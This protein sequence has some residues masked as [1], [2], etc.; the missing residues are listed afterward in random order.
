MN[1]AT[2]NIS[3]EY[4]ITEI[5]NHFDSDYVI[6]AIKDKLDNLDFSSSLIQPNA[7][8][9]FEENFK[10]MKENFPGD[11]SNINIVRIRI[12]REIIDI[13]CSKFNL[14]FNEYDDTIDLYTA[15]FYLYEFLICN[16]NKIMISFFSSFII[17]NKDM[18]YEYINND[19]KKRDM[20]TAYNKKIFTDPKYVT[21]SANIEK[22]INYIATLDIKLVN[23]FQ[24]VYINPEVVMFLDNA[25][26]D[27]GNFF[28]DFYCVN[29]LKE[30]VLPIIITNIRLDLQRI[31]GNISSDS[32]QN[33]L[34][35]GEL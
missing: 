3:N 10:L 27:R 33:I 7:V 32:I 31:V 15:A 25:F 28:Y 23:I 21:I 20:S 14:Q 17:N 13:L 4:N 9:A 24:S 29:I 6:E 22:V 1:T 19:E 34:Y 18:L 26:A 5:L 8:A 35:K 16:R 30:S 12:Y 11:E 2:Y